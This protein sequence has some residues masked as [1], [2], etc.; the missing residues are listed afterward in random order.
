MK[1]SNVYKKLY[2]YTT[3]ESLVGII[4]QQTLWATHFKFLNDASEIELF[5]SRLLDFLPPDLV[6]E[7]EQL[8]ENKG[9]LQ[10]LTRS[11]YEETDR[12]IYI[13][14]FYG[15]HRDDEYINENGLLSQW[16]AYGGDGGCAIVFKTQN[17]EELLEQEAEANDYS[18]VH[19]TDIIYS[20]NEQKFRTD[21]A[22]ELE[23][24]AKHVEQHI[25][26]LKI[27]QEPVLDSSTAYPAFVKC[28]SRYKHR[29]FK[30]ENEVRVVAIPAPTKKRAVNLFRSARPEKAVKF[31]EK[32]GGLAPYIDLFDGLSRELPIDRIIIGP[33][34][35]KE[36]RAQAMRIMLR[37]TNIQVSISDI[38]YIG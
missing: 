27:G 11:L 7:Y 13:A 32:S 16:R 12:N 3:F 18:S 22:P 38:P 30:E 28:I 26:Q 15:E 36:K 25:A 5:S 23:C 19:L 8:S 29:G 4:Q 2:H 33:H 10:S 20:D 17:L 9:E 21:L 1:A 37:N 14:A 24:L 6:R 34:R 35:E 31:R